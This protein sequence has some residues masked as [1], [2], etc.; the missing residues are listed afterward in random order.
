MFYHAIASGRSFGQVTQVVDGSWINVI[1][2]PTR[3]ASQF[4]SRMLLLCSY[5]KM[6]LSVMKVAAFFNIC[7]L[8]IVSGMSINEEHASGYC[9]A[10]PSVA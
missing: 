9:V 7:I 6:H 2:V 3:V 5:I 8:F 4:I 1:F 10:K